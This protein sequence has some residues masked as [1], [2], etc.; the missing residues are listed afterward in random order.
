MARSKKVEF[1]GSQGD[2][3]AARFDMPDEEPHA[4]AL[5]AHCFSC[6]KDSL[7]ASRVSRALSQQGFGVLRFDFTGLGGSEGDFANT[8]FSSNVGDILA[9]VEFLRTHHLAPSLMI[10]HS[11]GGTAVLSAAPQVPEARAVAT[12]GAPAEP[13]HLEHRFAEMVDSIRKDGAAAVN[14]GGRDLT[15]TKEFL[16]DLTDQHLLD[17]IASMHKALIVFHAP[18]DEIVGIDNAAAIYQAAKHPKSFVSLDD[19][20]HLLTRKP[21]ATYVADVL[22]AWVE[23]YLPASDK[24]QEAA[25]AA[26]LPRGSVRVSESGDGPYGQTVET[27]AHHFVA[28]EPADV[29][30]HNSGPSPYDLL[31]AALGACTSMTLRMYAQRKSWPLKKVTVT[32]AHEKLHA[33]DCVECESKEGRVDRIDRV[34]RIEGELD[35]E[36]RT[37][38][39]QIANRCPVHQTLTSETVIIDR[40]DDA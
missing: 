16:E 12:I 21:D 13:A 19:A 9:A 27:S 20:N 18:R 34:I 23:R 33:D 36:Q 22:A 10:G 40:A 37:R 8:T 31:L 25:S 11:L 7:A 3:L 24:A 29:G 1:R 28:D 26:P 38:L 2:M 17:G 15:I 4:T 6:S 39:L 30:G 35:D 5:F 14:F 32:L